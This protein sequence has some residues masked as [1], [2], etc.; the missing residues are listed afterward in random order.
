VAA[1][2]IWKTN[3]SLEI[4]WPKWEII[5]NEMGK[6]R[7][8]HKKWDF[9]NMKGQVIKWANKFITRNEISKIENNK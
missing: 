3:L 9:Q 1:I 6:K 4:K 5:N 2:K 7:I 8:Y